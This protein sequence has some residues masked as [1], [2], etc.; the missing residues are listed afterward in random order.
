[1]PTDN[2][3]RGEGAAGWAV[4]LANV[5]VDDELA[6]AVEA[7]LRSGWWSSGPE[8][9]AFEAACRDYLGARFALA[10]A[11]GTA[12]LQLAL[13]AA[14]IG[15]G[16]EVVLPSLNFVAAA[17]AVS[18]TGAT[19]T[20]CDIR[21]DG[22]LNLDPDSLEAALT[23]RTKALLLLHYG[24]YPCD[25]EA[26]AGIAAARGIVVIED[27]AHAIGATVQGRFCG[28]FGLA[29]CFS[30]FSNKNLPVGEGGLLVTDDEDLY[31]RARLLRS[32]GMTTL[33]WD[34]HRGHA[35]DYDVVERGFNFRLDE[36]RATIGQVQL[37]RLDAENEAR[38][39]V[40]AQ[41]RERLADA[42]LVL[43]F[44]EVPDQTR[45]SFHLAVAVF[46]SPEAREAARERLR[47]RRVQTSVH[48]PPIHRFS[49]YADAAPRVPL[50]RT[51][52]VAAR[53]LT[54]PLFG[55]MREDQV[56]LVA[57]T[58]LEQ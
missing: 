3:Q 50:G 12:A 28:T 4:P 14:G 52:S 39:R 47:E 40:V 37:R 33:T 34:R 11:N 35:A 5:N 19:A 21:G 36:V 23:P 10:V 2:P 18:H 29:G 13:L 9:E 22:D 44:A 17:N 51:E 43:P 58:L 24:G 56:D 27:S 25:V 20:F 42:D 7:T 54:L 1:V 15:P 30:F 38:R 8:V 31:S 55:H 16:D 46:R 41:Y 48:Y 57:Q 32:H 53:L 6:A 26:V 49:A 45:P